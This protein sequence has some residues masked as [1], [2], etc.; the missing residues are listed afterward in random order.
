MTKQ[1]QTNS[2]GVL[3]PFAFLFIT[4]PQ[5]WIWIQHWGKKEQHVQAQ[6]PHPLPPEK[7]QAHFNPVSERSLVI[8]WQEILA[9]DQDL[10]FGYFHTEREL[11]L[12]TKAHISHLLRTHS[13]LCT[14]INN[15]TKP[16]R[17][18]RKCLTPCIRN[19]LALNIC[20]FIKRRIFCAVCFMGVFVCVTF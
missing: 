8:D 2:V 13:W 14:A 16:D 3:I 12:P 1:L 7:W 6:T 18:S 10:P 19:R 11:L 5:C 20:P 9:L 4:V 17:M 15:M